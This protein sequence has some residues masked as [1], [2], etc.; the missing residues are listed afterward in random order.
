MKR[1][2]IITAG[3]VLATLAGTAV[4]IRNAPRQVQGPRPSDWA[5]PIQMVG[6]PN[7]YKVSTELY[8]SAQPIAEGV[9]NLKKL[10]I[11]TIINLRSFDS[12]RGKLGSARLD[13]EHIAAEVRPCRMR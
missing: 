11:K 5:E 3:L 7:L 2:P 10:G 6:V 13:Y 4:C 9:T 12:D 8:R 1:A